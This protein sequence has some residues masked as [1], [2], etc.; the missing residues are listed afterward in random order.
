MPTI[1]HRDIEIELEEDFSG[2]VELTGTTTITVKITTE[3]TLASMLMTK[4]TQKLLAYIFGVVFTIVLLAIAF[5]TPNP[6]AFQYTVFRIV[7]AL[8][9]AGMAA[10]IPGFLQATISTWLQAGG[11]LAI[12][13][14]VYFYSPAALVVN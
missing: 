13:V 6:T 5:A 8:A 10:M 14:I 1:K 11:A 9:A 7:L 2:R 12:F 3:K 4:G